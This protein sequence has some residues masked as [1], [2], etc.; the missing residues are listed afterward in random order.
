MCAPVSNDPISVPS[1][2]VIGKQR[3]M[4]RPYQ[5]LP[6]IYYTSAITSF[7]AYHFPRSTDDEARKEGDRT[8]LLFLRAAIVIVSF[9][10][11]RE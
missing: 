9:L 1:R 6:T 3:T 2:I 4:T 8:V 5:V 11:G 10:G 7:I